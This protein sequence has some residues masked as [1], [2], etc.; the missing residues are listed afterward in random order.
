MLFHTI[1]YMEFWSSFKCLFSICFFLAKIL[2]SIGLF[3]FEFM[4]IFLGL[5]YEQRLVFC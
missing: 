5:M 2:G 3:V 1:C 4:A